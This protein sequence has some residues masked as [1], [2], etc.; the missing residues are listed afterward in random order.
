MI[1]RGVSDIIERFAR[2]RDYMLLAE[3]TLNN[4]IP[5]GEFCRTDCFRCRVR[6]RSQQRNRLPEVQ[7]PFT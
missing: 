1:R 5:V 6:C 7:Q 3:P 2:D 4:R